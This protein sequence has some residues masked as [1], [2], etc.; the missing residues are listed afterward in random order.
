MTSRAVSL[1]GPR[2]VRV[3]R[4]VT[5]PPGAGEV[6]VR[7]IAAGVCGTD[8]HAWRGLFGRFPIVLGHDVAGVIEEVGSGVD[9]ARRGERVA[10]DP[11][12]CCRRAAVPVPWCP[13]CRRNA[14]HL[15]RHATY[16]GMTAPGAFAER[17]VVP[18]ARAVPLP[19]GL[20]DETA[21]V[22]EPV[23]VGL[24]LLEVVADRPGPVLVIGGGPMGIVAARLLA[25]NGRD[26]ELWE[27]LAVRRDAARASGVGQVAPP[28]ADPMPRPE[29]R[30]VVETS[31]HS[32]AAPLLLAVAAPATTIVLVGGAVDIPAAAILTREL[33]VRA[34][35]GGRGLY[36]EAVAVVA[37]GTVAPGALITH[38]WPICQAA[39]A[40][41]CV[42]AHPDE[43]V[44]AVLD[45]RYW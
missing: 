43:V 27:P 7:T 14:T 8:V 19:A 18:A 25:R 1:V 12:A 33:E 44:R 45:A 3:V 17:L 31:G 4:H 2:E 34:A 6:L 20:D 5:E 26:V 32:S 29:F 30:V 16:M 24:H 10:V 38:R 40:L 21:T 39:D 9:P 28:P 11:A 23:A 41:A 13:A 42:A 37:A 36:P 22:L 15:C 35:K